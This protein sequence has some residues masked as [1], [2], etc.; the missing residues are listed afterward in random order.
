MKEIKSVE[1][2]FISGKIVNIQREVE[3]NFSGKKSKRI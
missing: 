3:E 1:S 2:N